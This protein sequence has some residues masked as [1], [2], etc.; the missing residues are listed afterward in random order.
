MA[1]FIDLQT[2]T[3]AL[4]AATTALTTAITTLPS[5]GS[6]AITSAQADSIVSD[7]QAATGAITAATQ[8][9]TPATGGILA[10]IAG[11]LTVPVGQTTQ[12]SNTTPGGIWNSSN[13]AV[14]TVDNNG[15]V[16]TLAAGSAVI[17]YTVGGNSVSATVSAV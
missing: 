8:L 1:T 14:A 5:G 9:L 11:T 12:L 6:G 2:A 10:P 13:Q 17:T 15:L 3:A 16:T 4:K 7:I